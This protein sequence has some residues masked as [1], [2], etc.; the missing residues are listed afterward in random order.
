VKS[1]RPDVGSASV[2][3]FFQDLDVPAAISRFLYLENVRFGG[4]TSLRA[5]S[6]GGPP[7]V[8]ALARHPANA[9][10]KLESVL[11]S[12]DHVATAIKHAIETAFNCTVYNHYGMTKM[13][14]GGGVDCAAR[15]GMLLLRYRT[16]DVSRFIPDPGPCGTRLKTLERI[17][18]R[19]NGRVRIGTRYMTMADLD[20]AL[21]AIDGELNFAA[22]MAH[23]NGRDSLHLEVKIAEDRRVMSI[24]KA[25]TAAVP[26][27]QHF[28]LRVSTV[29]AMPPSMAKRTLLDRRSL[30]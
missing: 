9:S 27:A 30:T 26:Y 20:E 15:R 23:E 14:L 10:I 5:L 28:D 11:L 24:V 18:H 21:F 29:A 12:T 4:D 7:H 16:G 8:L 19:L 13:G 2:E 6:P 3:H 1:R 17:T 22:T 25:T